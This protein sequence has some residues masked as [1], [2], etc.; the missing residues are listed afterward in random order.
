MI[1]LD[2]IVKE[3][4]AE[5]LENL[6]KLDQDF[7]ELESNP[8]D[9]ERLAS[10]FRVIHTVKG[11]CGFL[12]FS[13][14]E[15]LAHAGENLLSKLRDGVLGLNVDI[16]NALLA[17]VDAVRAMLSS[18]ESTGTDGE[19]E[20]KEL[21][22]TL[23][24]LQRSERPAAATNNVKVS[25]K[26]EKN[27]I[28]DIKPEVLTENHESMVA[29][30][31]SEQ[32]PIVEVETRT[33]HE[34]EEDS[35]VIVNDPAGD[36][37]GHGVTDT[38][39]RVDVNLLDNLMNLVG[40]L[41][42][43]RNQVVQLGVKMEDSTFNGALQRLNLITSELQEGVMKTRMQ[44]IGNAWSK[45]PRVVRDLAKACN[46]QVRLVMEGK[47][48]E[49]DKSLIESIRDP[50]THMVRNAVDHGI[51]SPEDRIKFGKPE[52]GTLI[53]RSYHQGGQVIIDIID[54]GKGIDCNRVIKKALEKGLISADRAKSMTMR[55]I[56][57][58][59]FMAGF[60]TA[61][62]VTNVSGRGVGMDVVKTNIEKIGGT[63][64]TISELG[65]GTTFRVTI[66]LTLAI[67]PALIVSCSGQKFAIPQVSLL[68][69]LRLEREEISKNIEHISGAPIY[70]LRGKLLPLVYLEKVLERY[71]SAASDFKSAINIVVLQANERHFGL[72]VD[73]IEDS[74][75]IVV[76]PLASIL[77]ALTL[78]AGVTILGDGKAALILDVVDLGR[79]VGLENK[80]QSVAA[81]EAVATK[82]SDAE[83]IHQMLICQMPSGGH[84]VIPLSQVA[85]LEK[86][87]NA[88][89]EKSGNR[90]VVQ[91]RG[92]I[93]Q[94]LDVE[95]I[96][97]G[98]SGTFSVERS[99][100]D[101]NSIV[102]V[103]VY[104]VNQ[105]SVGLVVHKIEDIIESALE[106]QRDI[107]RDGVIT[108]AVI[109]DQVMEVLDVNK[110]IR[111]SGQRFLN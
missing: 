48:T 72:V 110:I 71:D 89:L 46:K 25:K 17:L 3:F 39:I 82:D 20:Y 40:E 13:K 66:P 98:G 99:E 107:S 94:V 24:L 75:E 35:K 33:E 109:Q 91:Y 22:E 74:Q 60:S 69:V 31:S 96:L 28:D 54:D 12:G 42:L 100:N 37:K 90:L 50:L 80:S 59:L 106:I 7:V 23:N 85:R 1:E 30:S 19:I 77:S 5:S 9:A 34:V 62:K 86:I 108:T 61:E 95:N 76:K 41:V 32:I 87:K 92:E 84:V 29:P 70:R 49:L 64:E 104:T 55:D 51:E 111:M 52:E 56:T 38:S 21:I 2:E 68:E 83:D 88:S 10:I 53:L 81:S 18:I 65:K 26:E 63:I 45:F 79:R 4:L 105:H 78:F 47:D 27:T 43:T 102:D 15:S 8:K 73:Q 58:L 97:N 14:L 36:Q 103:V 44:P 11:T 16:T 93:M 6:D 57:D 101:K 67:V